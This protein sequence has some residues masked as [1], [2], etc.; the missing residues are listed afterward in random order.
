MGLKRSR[1]F[2]GVAF[3]WAGRKIFFYSRI[4]L[5]LLCYGESVRQKL[6]NFLVYYF[7]LNSTFKYT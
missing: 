2:L 5:L 6:G 3:K 4:I 1:N 7:E